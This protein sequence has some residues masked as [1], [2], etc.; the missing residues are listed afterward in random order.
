ME[1][2]MAADV[3]EA[4][5]QTSSDIWEPQSLT[6]TAEALVDQL[7]AATPRPTGVFILEDRLLPTINSA[8]LARGIHTGRDGD[9]E[10]LSCNNE[11]PHLAGFQQQPATVDIRADL[12][13]QQGVKQLLWRMKNRDRPERASLL[14][15]PVLI[16]S[17][18][19]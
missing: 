5:V 17:F 2:G 3:I 7:L 4:D 13:G 11:R 10:I 16:E 1:M 14:I 8:L 15:E 12:I 9:I 18:G 6:Q 19:N